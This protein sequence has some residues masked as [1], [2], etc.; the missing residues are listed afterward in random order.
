MEGSSLARLIEKGGVYVG[1][2]GTDPEEI[3]AD[4]AKKL[5]LPDTFD[6]DLVVKEL[7]D[8]ENVLSTAVGSGLAVPHPKRPV[9]KSREDERI[10][11]C[12]LNR[13]ISMSAPDGRPVSVFFILL[14][15]SQVSHLKSLSLLAKLF[16]DESFKKI[17]ETKPLKAQLV[18]FL[19]RLSL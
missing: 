1:I 5:V 6:R 14:S 2:E 4:L 11:V 18:A 9:V 8:R 19:D 12:Y 10:I 7:M 16:R 13:K 3:F 15:S 17:I